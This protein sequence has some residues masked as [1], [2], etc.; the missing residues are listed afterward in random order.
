MMAILKN[1]GGNSTPLIIAVV[2]V[3]LLLSCVISEFLRLN[4][5]VKGVRNA[6]Q[7]AVISVSTGNYDEVYNGLR[8]GYSGGY[9][10]FNG[11]WEE[12][13]D[14]GDVYAQIDNLLGLERKNGYHIKVQGSG[15]EYRLWGLD[16]EIKNTPLTPGNTDENFEADVRIQIEVP[17]SFGWVLLPPLKMEVRT[18][19]GYT[20]KF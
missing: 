7:A 18:R 17:L 9:T 19:S 3:L 6:M 1:K 12:T 4:V 11:H 8:E 20:P 5:I 14:Y 13:F 10:L 16:I 15:Y 2:L